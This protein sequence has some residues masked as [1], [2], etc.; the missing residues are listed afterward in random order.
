MTDLSPRAV[1]VVVIIAVALIVARRIIA[2]HPLDAATV[3][4]ALLGWDVVVRPMVLALGLDVPF[5]DELFADEG[6]TSCSPGPHRSSCSAIH[7]VTAAVCASRPPH[8]GDRLADDCARQV[9]HQL[10][11]IAAF[12]GGVLSGMVIRALKHRFREIAS[13]LSWTM[14]VML[15]GRVFSG[16][17]LTN[18]LN[19]FLLSGVPMQVLAHVAAPNS[20]C[21]G[22]LEPFVERD[23]SSAPAG[24]VHDVEGG[25][26]VAVRCE[27]FPH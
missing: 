25:E 22:G 20:D 23:R 14:T 3:T 2:H 24:H 26:E 16:G 9:V 21:D 17:V 6:S 5:P 13:P 18:S 7:R 11:P 8:E 19:R 12:V 15:V 27:G 1:F 10:R 4:V